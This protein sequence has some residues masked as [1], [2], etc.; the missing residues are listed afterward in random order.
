[1]ANKWGNV[2]FLAN[3]TK[4]KSPVEQLFLQDL[5][6]SIELQ[7]A[8]EGRT[9]SQTYKPSSMNCIRNMYYQVTG[10]EQDKTGTSYSFIGICNSG[11]DTHERIQQS[12]LDMQS[13]GIDCEYVNVADYV[14]Q[15]ELDYLQ[16]K[17]KPNFKKKEFETKLFHK[18]LNMS[19]L[20]DGIVR[21]KDKY[22]ILEIK[23]ET[24]NKWYGREG[25]DPGH[26]NQGT[27]YSIAFGIDDV[28]FLY[29]NRDMCD[30]KSF[31]FTPTNDMKQ[32]LIGKITECDGYVKRLIAPPKPTD[33]AR[34]T[35]DYCAYKT[36]CRK[37]G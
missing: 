29:I 13:N 27:A 30:I 37:D 24:S 11:T 4:E 28:I 32:E 31:M 14:K 16:I 20:C 2:L 19:F 5:K 15:R 12:V 26:Y 21:Y 23:T 10:A 33:V 17:K 35:C 7:N 6:R 1:M 36:Q 3:Q 9:P 18:K 22:Y 25:V 8:K 34:K